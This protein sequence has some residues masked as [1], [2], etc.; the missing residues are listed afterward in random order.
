M[1]STLRV[2]T[3]QV[4]DADSEYASSDDEE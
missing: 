2:T 1:D 4:V 3:F